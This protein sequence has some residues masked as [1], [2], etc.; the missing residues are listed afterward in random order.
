MQTDV[1]WRLPLVAFILKCHEIVKRHKISFTELREILNKAIAP[2]DPWLAHMWNIFYGAAGKEW[3]EMPSDEVIAT[4]QEEYLQKVK[5]LNGQSIVCAM[6]AMSAYTPRRAYAISLSY[7]GNLTTAHLSELMFLARKRLRVYVQKA[8]TNSDLVL[9]ILEALAIL[10]E[11]DVTVST[12]M[13]LEMK[14]WEEL[15]EMFADSQPAVHV[16]APAPITTSTESQD[17]PARRTSRRGGVQ[18]KI[19]PDDI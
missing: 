14:E 9:D 3:S 4:R 19:S 10:Y 13:I 11:L 17:P 12:S 7:K 8:T 2:G 18:V 6:I 15:L 16:P 1:Q 5:C